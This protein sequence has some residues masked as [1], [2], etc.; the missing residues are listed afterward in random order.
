ML[1]KT[2]LARLL[3]TMPLVSALVTVNSSVVES[4][5]CVEE[6]HRVKSRGCA[7]CATGRNKSKPKRIATPLLHLLI[8]IM[9][10]LL[11]LSKENL[12]LCWVCYFWT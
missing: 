6:L 8:S 7:A 9:L 4:T 11:L 1:S 3:M 5:V 10:S 2:L 12:V